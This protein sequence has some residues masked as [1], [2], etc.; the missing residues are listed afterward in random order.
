MTDQIVST[1]PSLPQINSGV[2]FGPGIQLLLSQCPEA[3]SSLLRMLSIYRVSQK[4][5][6]AMEIQQAVVHH[7]LS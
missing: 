6:N 1:F 5:K 2:S 3:L 7:K 4:I